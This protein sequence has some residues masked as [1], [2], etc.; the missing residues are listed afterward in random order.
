VRRGPSTLHGLLWRQSR[1]TIVVM[2]LFVLVVVRIGVISYNASGGALGLAGTVPLLKNPAIVALY[3]RA[4]S[5]GSA[6]AFVAWKMGMF[7][8]L[9]VALWAGLLATRL[10][11]AGEDDGNWELVIAGP[12]GRRAVFSSVTGVLAEAG[13]VVGLMVFVGLASAG[14]HLAD[15]TD[16]ALAFTGV[17]W[18]GGSLG[19]LASQAVAPRR[20]AS[21]LALGVIGLTFLVRMVADGSSAGRWFSWVS[22][23]AWM[24]DVGSFQ[25]RSGGWLGALVAV[26]VVVTLAAGVLESRRDVGVAVWT[27]PD[28]ARAREGSLRTS[29]RFAWRERRGTLVTWSLGLSALGLVFGY[30][31]NALVVFARSDAAYVT[32]L[33][34][35]GLQSMVTPKGFVAETG[36]IVAV[37]LGFLVVSLVVMVGQDYQRGRLD[38]PFAFGPSRWRWYLS[39]LASALIATVVLS[40]VCGLSVWAGVRASGTSMSVLD[41]LKGLLNVAAPVPLFLGM[42]ALLVAAVPR[43]AYV[44]MSL[45]IGLAYLVAVLGPTLNWPHA[46]VD[47]SP[48]HYLAL[49][50]AVAPDWGAAVVFLV[51]GLACA[52][53]GVVGFTRRD[54]NA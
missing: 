54:I 24:E 5:L 23:F 50:P 25:R 52:A 4:S 31:T 22:P 12:P 19:L 40:V 27:R 8:A 33:K 47:L 21:Q 13:L 51:A 53:L 46:V 39:A 32:L 38:L 20:S 35:W 29:W 26:P 36:S 17:A 49:V 9:G 41:P 18:F 28:R 44:V 11:R 14:Q 10:V 3:G 7:L 45:F 2:A 43:V 37:L 42:I 34:R 15:T 1:V 6:G 30:L 48:F 16:Y